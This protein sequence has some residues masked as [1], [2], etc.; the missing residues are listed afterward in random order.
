MKHIANLLALASIF[1][2]VSTD[3][4]GLNKK[5]YKPGPAAPTYSKKKVKKAKVVKKK[6]VAKGAQE[7][8]EISATRS[9]LSRYMPTADQQGQFIKAKPDEAR[10]L[11]RLLLSARARGVTSQAGLRSVADKYMMSIGIERAALPQEQGP[12]EPEL[13]VKRLAE[14]E[15]A[16]GGSLQIKQQ[17]VAWNMAK[18][19]YFDEKINF[20]QLE[21][22][23]KRTIAAYEQADMWEQAQRVSVELAQLREASTGPVQIVVESAGATPPSEPASPMASSAAAA[24]PQSSVGLGPR[25]LMA[26]LNN[27]TGTIGRILREHNDIVDYQSL[28]SGDTALIIA[29]RNGHREAVEVLLEF[30]ADPTLQ[31]NARERA[32]NVARNEHIRQIIDQ[33]AV[34]RGLAAVPAAAAAAAGT[35]LEQ[36]PPLSLS[37]QMV[38]IKHVAAAS[39]TA[40][41]SAAPAPAEAAA[42]AAA[43]A[44]TPAPAAAV[45]VAAIENFWRDDVVRGYRSRTEAGVQSPQEAFDTLKE[46]GDDLI[47]QLR[48]AGQTQAAEKMQ[49]ELDA[50]RAEVAKA[51]APAVTPAPAAASV[52]AI[53]AAS[54]ETATAMTV[55]REA[56]MSATH[57]YE[58]SPSRQEA[59]RTINAN[60]KTLEE[61][62]A[63]LIE[64]RS[65]SDADY[66]QVAQ[67]IQTTNNLLDIARKELARVTQLPD[68]TPIPAAVAPAPTP[69]PASA[70]AATPTVDDQ[71]NLG[72]APTTAPK[73][74]MASTRSTGTP[75]RIRRS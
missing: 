3:L 14:A 29:A 16:L 63:K 68:I 45:D 60:I 4:Q 39:T 67:N 33:N 34:S 71:L 47:K 55:A 54:K 38:D 8:P 62:Q 5:K 22:I 56:W 25:L 19:D 59:L 13:G 18:K 58:N 66:G 12:R 46:N 2:I 26:A 74:M 57:A 24:A 73:T 51:P 20:A 6:K 50:I 7:D 44:V 40:P 28:I 65:N 23:G 15:K 1:F 75:R 21:V 61:Q 42:A 27:N 32:V 30:N 35:G 43:P 31:N 53:A 9:M 48:D 70:P 10:E 41:T 72:K 37:S 17:A 36:V 11:G 49:K 52:A 64:L 69:A